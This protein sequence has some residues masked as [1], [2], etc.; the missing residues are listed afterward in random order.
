MLLVYGRKDHSFYRYADLLERKLPNNKLVLI[1]G[2][3]HQIPTKAA[4]SM[5]EIIKQW[6]SVVHKEQQVV[7]MQ[8]TQSI[9]SDSTFMESPPPTLELEDEYIQ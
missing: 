2:V 4:L 3:S 5:N 1:R 7:D 8:A 6:L 9:I